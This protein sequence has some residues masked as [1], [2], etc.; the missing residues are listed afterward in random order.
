MAGVDRTARFHLWR[1]QPW[2]RSLM[3]PPQSRETIGFE[4]ALPLR[5]GGGTPADGRGDLAVRGAVGEH[6]HRPRAVRP[7]L[8]DLCA[9]ARTPAACDVRQP[10]RSAHSW[11]TARAILTTVTIQVN[12]GDPNAPPPMSGDMTWTFE[13][14]PQTNMQ[15]LRTTIRSTHPWLTTETTGSTALS[16]GNSPPTGISTHGEFNSPRGCRG[17]FGS[18][19]TAEAAR[20]EADFT[21]TDCQLATFTGRV[22]VDEG[23]TFTLPLTV[24]RSLPVAFR[25]QC[26]GSR[27]SRDSHDSDT[28]PIRCLSGTGTRLCTFESSRHARRGVRWVVGMTPCVSMGP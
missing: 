8:H 7:G 15:S 9:S 2:L 10:S 19:G 26:A 3:T 24:E 25:R 4:A 11:R 14:V 1:P 16:P 18:V 13:V 12:P 21:G 17:T 23:I 27:P 5:G 6:E 28:Y 22:R 20:I